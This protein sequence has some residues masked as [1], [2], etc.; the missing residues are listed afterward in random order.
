MKLLY[1]DDFKSLD[2]ILFLIRGKAKDIEIYA[3]EQIKRSQE[4]EKLIK[5]YFETKEWSDEI[6]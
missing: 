1:Q 2:E 3:K 4:L 6:E 5:E